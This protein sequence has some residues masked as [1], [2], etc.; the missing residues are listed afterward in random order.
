VLLNGEKNG[1]THRKELAKN[2]HKR[3]LKRL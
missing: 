2:S 1:K 3:C